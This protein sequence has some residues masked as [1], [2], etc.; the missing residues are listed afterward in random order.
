M[1]ISFIALVTLEKM[2]AMSDLLFLIICYPL[3]DCLVAPA[4]CS[5]I[6]DCL[7][8]LVAS[9]MPCSRLDVALPLPC[10]CLAVALPLPCR[11]LAVTLP[12]PR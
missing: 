4:I 7:R 3:L 10:R 9:S 6:A 1:A 8:I 12:L 11:Y 5:A 2:S